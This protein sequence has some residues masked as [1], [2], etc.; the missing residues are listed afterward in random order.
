M[1]APCV[2]RCLNGSHAMACLKRSL[3]A[4]LSQ[5]AFTVS[6]ST[7]FEFVLLKI[8]FIS[9]LSSLQCTHII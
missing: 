2:L 6:H 1:I 7:E 3:W 8:I 4:T 9:V 5:R